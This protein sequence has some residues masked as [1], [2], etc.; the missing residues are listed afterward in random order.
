M[1]EITHLSKVNIKI[2]TI[3]IIVLLIAMIL[4]IGCSVGPGTVTIK[5]FQAIE[6]GNIDEAISYY[7]TSTIQSLG[8]D[9]W[10]AVLLEGANRFATAGGVKSV[11]I[12][13]EMID[14][15]KAQ[16]TVRV[17]LG[18]GS[19]LTDDFELVKEGG[20]WKIQW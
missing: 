3:A 8:Y 10:Q 16:V 11:N 2:R 6:K 7:S 9:K 14:G 18:D 19:I 1:A 15:D 20:V 12:V 4:L 17:R 5:Y 13:S